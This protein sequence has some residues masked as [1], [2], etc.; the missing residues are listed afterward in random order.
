MDSF[1]PLPET[2]LL[3]LNLV[4]VLPHSLYV[5]LK[6]L[7]CNE[8]NEKG[9]YMTPDKMESICVRFLIVHQM[10]FILKFFRTIQQKATNECFSLWLFNRTENDF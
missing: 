3:T 10:I 7:Q 8:E 1:L 5:K 6:H 4:G 2:T 9:Q